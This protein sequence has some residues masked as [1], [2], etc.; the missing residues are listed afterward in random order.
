MHNFFQSVPGL[1]LT[2]A[3]VNHEVLIRL[4]REDFQKS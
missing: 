3:T 1:A 4:E 2:D